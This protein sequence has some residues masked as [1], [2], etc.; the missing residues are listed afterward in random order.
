[1][2]RSEVRS[3]DRREFLRRL[4]GLAVTAPIIGHT[5]LRARPQSPARTGVRGDLAWLAAEVPLL[6]ARLKVPGLAIALVEN[7]A[8]LWSGGFGVKKAGEP[9]L[10]TSDTVFEAA[11]LSKP[12]FAYV[13][14]KLAE[15]GR[16][17]L[18]AGIGDF[19]RMPDFM[20][21]PTV[22]A[23]TPR[24]VLAHQTG[25]PNWRGPQP[26]TFRFKPGSDFSYSGESYV[27][28]QRFVEKTT[29]MKLDELAAARILR[30]WQMAR[31]AYLWRAGFDR[32]SVV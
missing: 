30:P 3:A 20:N 1:M 7:G 27:R 6:L 17:D 25:L 9:A 22:N 5:P 14:Q 15:E 26:A 18:D 28:L 2:T 24:I 11:S 12:P 10:V 31:T 29:G 16:I 13:V 8:P 23:I 21:D 19:F 4:A 32:K